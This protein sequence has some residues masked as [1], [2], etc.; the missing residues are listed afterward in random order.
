MEVDYTK[1]LQAIAEALNK[2]ANP[3]WYVP[4][5]S[6]LGGMVGGAAI[7][8]LVIGFNQWSQKRQL[9]RTIYADLGNTFLLLYGYIHEVYKGKENMAKPFSEIDFS[10][11]DYAKGKPEIYIQ[12]RDR[13]K[14]ERIYGYLK[15]VAD[16]DD[17]VN[18]SINGHWFL[19]VF[20]TEVG[21]GSLS[22]GQ[23]TRA[24]GPRGGL[25]IEAVNKVLAIDKEHRIRQE[26]LREKY[27]RQTDGED[28][29][30]RGTPGSLSERN[31]TG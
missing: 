16:S 15:T 5:F 24:M 12:L 28:A 18:A 19:S 8:G 30:N 13:H 10:V 2:P 31:G 7:Q 20:A 11:R 3:W 22:E 27:R 23:F 6:S 25:L 14:F 1:Q 9:T 17:A 4:L 26:E 29:E 21:D